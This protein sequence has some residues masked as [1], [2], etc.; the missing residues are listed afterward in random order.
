VSISGLWAS[1]A[2]IYGRF[3]YGVAAEAD[4]LQIERAGSLDVGRG[5]ELDAVD[6]IDEA[7]AREL[8]PPIY[9]RA[10]AQR[11]GALIRTDVWWRERRFVE[12]PF[13]RGG[14]SR[15]RHVVAQRAGEPVGYL[16]FRQRSGFTAEL[17]SGKL[18]I[19]ELIAIDARA[20]ATLWSVACN[21]DLFPTV[22]WGN[23]PIDDLVVWL[24]SDPR[25]VARKRTDNLWLRIDDVAT[26]LAARRYAADGTLRLAIDDTTWELAVEAGVARCAPT[27]RPAELRLSRPALGALYLGGIRAAHL[28]R[29]ERAHG[30]AAAIATAD[31]L[32][33]SSIAPWCP[34]LF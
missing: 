20:E 9:A 34:E 30:D 27:S 22:S 18:E 26:A 1:E 15:L 16:Q 21:A 8:L 24:V 2:S 25:R 6:W 11:P 32:F 23:A 4:V 29:A 10:T 31:R 3:G 33:A 17:P 14:A 7:R 19:V 28:A 12:A 13:M 5:R